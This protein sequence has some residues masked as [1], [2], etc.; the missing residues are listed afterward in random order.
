MIIYFSVTEVEELFTTFDYKNLITAVNTY[1]Q[2]E[3]KAQGISITS[4]SYYN[5][6][7]NK[8]VILYDYCNEYIYMR[9]LKHAYG[10]DFVTI[11]FNN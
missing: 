3:A 6:A 7:E 1:F 4:T 9:N 10:N 11:T 8:G 2:E 5:P